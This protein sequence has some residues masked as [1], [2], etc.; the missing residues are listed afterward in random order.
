MFKFNNIIADY[1]N[2]YSFLIFLGTFISRPDCKYPEFYKKLF[3]TKGH[4]LRYPVQPFEAIR[5]FRPT[6]TGSID[7][8]IVEHEQFQRMS[9]VVARTLQVESN[10]LNMLGTQ[11]NMDRVE[12]LNITYGQSS[13]KLPVTQLLGHSVTRSLGQSSCN[14]HFQ[15]CHEHTN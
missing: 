8:S 3:S 5:L 11:E 2:F 7:C 14:P 1:F 15:H 12:Y 13:A 10:T 4:F 9:V 6:L